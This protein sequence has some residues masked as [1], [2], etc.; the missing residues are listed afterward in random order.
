MGITN[1]A[2]STSYFQRYDTHGEICLDG[3]RK[4]KVNELLVNDATM[5]NQSIS[6][7]LD[8]QRLLKRTLGEILMA[9]RI[10]TRPNLF[11]CS[12]FRMTEVWFPEKDCQHG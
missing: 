4:R 11:L 10:I 6:H 3:D 5:S 2:S 8:A 1:L 9:A 12:G 7:S